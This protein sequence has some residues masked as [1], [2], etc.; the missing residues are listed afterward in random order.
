MYQKITIIGNLGRKPEMRFTPSGQAV[1]SFSVA[2]SEQYKNT[3]GETVKNT[4]WF[5]VQ[6]W[7]K[8]GEICNEYLDKGSKVYV[9]GRLDFDKATGAPKLWSKQDGSTGT[10]F[11]IRADV[12]KFLSSKHENSAT[13]SA[14]NSGGDELPY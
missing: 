4:A 2:V 6:A 14:E 1:T 13:E 7:G 3:S 9:E 12:V 10:A 5:R 8:L 11:E